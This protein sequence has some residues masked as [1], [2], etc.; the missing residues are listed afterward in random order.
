[1]IQNAYTILEVPRLAR[2]HTNAAFVP[3]IAGRRRGTR[4]GRCAC[5]HF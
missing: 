3:G 2:E 5:S 4:K 1:M